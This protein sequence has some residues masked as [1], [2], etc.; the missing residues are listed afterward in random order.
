MPI[1]VTGDLHFTL[2]IDGERQLSRKLHGYLGRVGNWA[3]FFE[4]VKADWIQTQRQIFAA[5]GAF[6]GQARWAPLS[7]RYRARKARKYGQADSI[8]IASGAMYHAVIEPVT[9][10]TDQQ[11]TLTV[12]SPYAVYHQ[13]ARERKSK[14]PRR[15]FASLTG[16]QKTRMMDALHRHI[17]AEE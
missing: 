6:E 7:E 2:D 3:P 11:M 10:I 14:L 9:E 17:F 12:D 4:E 13:S 15:A 5:Q 8:L 16:R 1:G